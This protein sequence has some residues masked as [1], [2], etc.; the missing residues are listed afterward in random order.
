M[1]RLNGKPLRILQITDCHLGRDADES[2][3]DDEKA[4]LASDPDAP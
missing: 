1:T 3:L 2:L 4:M